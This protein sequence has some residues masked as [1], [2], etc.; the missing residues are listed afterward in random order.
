[1]AA[2]GCLSEVR[3]TKVICLGTC[4]KRV[5]GHLIA[6]PK[7]VRRVKVNGGGVGSSSGP[8][9]IPGTQGELEKVFPSDFP[10]GYPILVK[11]FIG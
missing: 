8:I 5:V 3:G 2:Q 1:M 9:P 6:N 7:S 4:T 10:L 11:A